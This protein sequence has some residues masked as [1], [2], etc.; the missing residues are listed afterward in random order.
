MAA[1]SAQSAQE[2]PL[3]ARIAQLDKH[4]YLFGQKLAASMSP[5][6]HQVIYRELGLNWDQIRLD[7][8]DMN[9]FLR[10]IRHPD[11]YGL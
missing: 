6:L 8:L 10:L 11:F 7:S 4:G 3:T 2:E 9:L 1:T 5:G